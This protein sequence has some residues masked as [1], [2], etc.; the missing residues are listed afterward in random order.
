MGKSLFSSEAELM[1]F[2]NMERSEAEFAALTWE[3]QKE[4]FKMLDQKFKEDMVEMDA[5]VEEIKK[6][7]D[8]AGEGLTLLKVSEK[9]G[10]GHEKLDSAE[11]YVARGVEYY[12]NSRFYLSI[13][14]FDEAVELDPNL[15]SAYLHRGVWYQSGNFFNKAIADYNKAIELDP[16]CA[17]AYSNRNVAYVKRHI[18]DDSVATLLRKTD[19]VDLTVA[20]CTEA[21]KRDPMDAEMYYKRAVA[22]ARKGDSDKAEADYKKAVD[23]G[24][25]EYEE[26]YFVNMDVDLVIV[27]SG[28]WIRREPNN[29]IGY[30]HRGYGY[31]KKGELDLAIADFTEAIRLC[32]DDY[33]DYYLNRGIAYENKGEIKTAFADYNEEIRLYPNCSSAY[34]NRSRLYA[35][36]GD[37][38]SAIADYAKFSALVINAYRSDQSNNHETDKH[39]YDK[40]AAELTIALTTETIRRDPNDVFA[41]FHRGNRYLEKGET[42]LAL[43]DYKEAVRRYPDYE[44]AKNAIAKLNA[45]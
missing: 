26:P 28:N 1:S 20:E 9:Y 6:I 24:F 3:Q 43:A 27:L 23:L 4:V 25:F 11:E 33:S 32:G 2:V 38:N 7:P 39:I 36:I 29:A 5:M 44:E 17:E 34:Y 22:Y 16:N 21:I 42:D 40:D 10:P 41:Y 19:D 12:K 15:A 30:G 18:F 45:G 37:V 35:R 8:S 14:D 31:L 13:K